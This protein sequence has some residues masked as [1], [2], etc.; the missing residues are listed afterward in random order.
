M[1]LFTLL[2]LLFNYWKEREEKNS[3]SFFFFFVKTWNFPPLSK[4][5]AQTSPH[6]IISLSTS[7][8]TMSNREETQNWVLGHKFGWDS[9]SFMDLFLSTH[10][11]LMLI[12]NNL[13]F[14]D[15]RIRKLKVVR[16]LSVGVKTTLLSSWED[17]K[18]FYWVSLEFLNVH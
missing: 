5:W 14:L 1:V 17:L 13:W 16:G 18:W 15:T 3:G 10:L 6:A 11:S 8:F 9:L 7:L 12:F 4:F 2:E